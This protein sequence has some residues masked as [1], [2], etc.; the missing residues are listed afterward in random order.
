MTEQQPAHH[1]RYLNLMNIVFFVGALLCGIVGSMLK[2][3]S[4]VQ[5]SLYQFSSAFFIAGCT[6]SGSKLIREGWDIPAAGFTILAISQGIYYASLLI[7][8]PERLPFFSSGVPLF[9]PGMV[10]IFFYRLF[11][12]WVRI[13]GLTACLPFLLI[14]IYSLSN[15]GNQNLVIALFIAG[16]TIIDITSLFWAFY[17][18]RNYRKGGNAKG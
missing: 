10:L 16:F 3:E 2:T 18:W 14:L 6:T 11:P 4:A 9:L 8:G 5:T 12:L 17:F 1:D 15:Y 7:H 13:L